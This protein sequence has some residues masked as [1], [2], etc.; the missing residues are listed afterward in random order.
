MHSQI[1]DTKHTKTFISHHTCEPLLLDMREIWFSF[2]GD[3]SLHQGD[4]SIAFL[5]C[6]F[7]LFSIKLERNFKKYMNYRESRQF[8][9]KT[10]HR[11]GFWR[12]FT[13]RI[14]DSSL[15]F[16]KTV[17]Q[18]F[19]L[20]LYSWSW[21]SVFFYHKMIYHMKARNKFYEAY[22]HTM[23]LLLD[24]DFYE[25]HPRRCIKGFLCHLIE[26]IIWGRNKRKRI[27][28]TGR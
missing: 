4:C 28:E 27:K 15:T 6:R 3:W 11:Q 20:Y 16:L 22:L 18:N 10:V 24:F 12:Q 8:T 14:E 21:K 5:T 2:Q 13:D 7:K 23:Y 26:D 9:D 25:K 17:R 1:N 19:I